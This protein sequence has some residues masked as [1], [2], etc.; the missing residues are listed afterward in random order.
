MGTKEVAATFSGPSS[1]IRT[2][3]SKNLEFGV[4]KILEFG[5]ESTEAT[6]GGRHLGHLDS[7]RTVSTNIVTL[8]NKRAAVK[9]RITNT[10]K[11][12]ESTIEQYGRKAIIRGYVNNLQE[13]LNKAKGLNDELVS[14]IPENEHEAAIDWYEE[15]LDRVEDAKL[16]ANAHLTSG[17]RKVLAD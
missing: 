1:R 16:Q 2:S 10:L 8:K 17:Q 6:D 11:K 3:E 7:A 4:A 9:R 12:L 13:Y 14:V 15:Q 5:M